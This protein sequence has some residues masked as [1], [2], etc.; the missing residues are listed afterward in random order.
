MNKGLPRLALTF[1]LLLWTCVCLA[2]TL[3]VTSPLDGSYVGANSQLN[4]NISGASL[5]VTVQALITYPGGA[6]STISNTFDPNNMGQITGQLPL[7]FN[8]GDP[9]GQYTIVVSATEPNNS[10][11][12][13]TL[14]VTVLPTPPLFN[15]FSPA[16]GSFVNGVVHI[17]ASLN[18]AYLKQWLVQVNGQNIPNN[19]GTTTTVSVDWN[20]ASVPNDGQE[21]VTIAATDLAGNTATKTATLTLERVPPVLS[22]LTPASGAKIVPGTDISITLDIQGEFANAIDRT[23]IDV[24]AETPTGAFIARASVQ[25]FSQLSGGTTAQWIGRIRYR[26]GL[27]PSAFK[28]VATAYDKA[29][30]AASPQTI[31]LTVGH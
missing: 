9:Q 20:T 10:Y 28:I 2:G 17:R 3:T 25:V 26:Q 12:P 4:F 15:S 30:N 18:E 21:T 5:Q 8:S 6:T 7:G 29:G 16:S 24:L 23:G 19:S 1:L 13:T 11:A 14:T 27:L 22:I 31:S